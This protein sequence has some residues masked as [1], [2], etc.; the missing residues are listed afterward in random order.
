[1]YAFLIVPIRATYPAN[2]IIPDLNILIIFRERYKL[3]V[4]V[5]NEVNFFFVCYF[6]KISPLSTSN[7]KLN[8]MYS[9]GSVCFQLND[10]HIKNFQRKA[11]P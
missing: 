2:H 7:P 9:N 11:C 1:L 6:F 10:T 4:C 3:C 8:V 5:C